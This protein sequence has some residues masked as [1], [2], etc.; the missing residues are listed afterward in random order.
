MIAGQLSTDGLRV[1]GQAVPHVCQIILTFVFEFLYLHCKIL[2]KFGLHN[3]H[4][5]KNQAKE[6]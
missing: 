5:L 1:Q 4:M 3:D 2:A 6:K